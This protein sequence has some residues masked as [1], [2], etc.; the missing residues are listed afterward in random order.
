MYSKNNRKFSGSENKTTTI[1]FRQEKL[2]EAI[3]CIAD[4]ERRREEDDDD[5]EPR[6]PM[7]KTFINH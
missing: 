1:L 3:D 5:D 4:A 2:Q 7:Q 6:S